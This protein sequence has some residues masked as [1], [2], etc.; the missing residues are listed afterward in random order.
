VLGQ[1]QYDP[2][3]FHFLGFIQPAELATLYNLSD[4]HVYLTVPYVLSQSLIQAMASECLILAS[5]TAPVQ[6]VI[7]DGEQ[8][9]LVDFY[10]VDNLTRRALQLLRSPEEYLPLRQAARQRAVREHSRGKCL[11]A[12]AQFFQ[13][14]EKQ[15][16][17]RLFAGLK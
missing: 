17:D 9:V 14:F 11:E 8:G 16:R 10:D 6:E 5:D 12:T 4:L 2:N 3:K 7:D 1:G 13:R 15:A